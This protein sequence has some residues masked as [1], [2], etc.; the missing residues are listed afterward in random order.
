MVAVALSHLYL[1]NIN[2]VKHYFRPF[3]L[4]F[5][6]SENGAACFVRAPRTHVGIV[7]FERLYFV[8]KVKRFAELFMIS[9]HNLV[10]FATSLYWVPVDIHSISFFLNRVLPYL[11]QFT[12][13]I[14][15]FVI[16]AAT[17]AAVLE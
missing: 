8:N 3:T 6:F 9:K 11:R 17:A 12:I 13:S 15:S 1:V 16:G 7:P 14:L 4:A 5:Y 2:L 10:F